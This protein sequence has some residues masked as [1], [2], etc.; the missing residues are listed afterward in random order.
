VT[1]D[2]VER[3]GA[4]AAVI[5]A[6]I[7]FRCV[8]D[9]PGRIDAEGER[10]WRV[11]RRQMGHEV[12]L[13]LKVVRRALQELGEV[14][15][16]KHFP[17]LEDQSLAYRVAE[18]ETPLTCQK[19]DRAR[20]DQPEAPQG[21]DLAPQ[22]SVPSPTGPGTEPHRASAPYVENLETERRKE[23]EAPCARRDL[24]ATATAAA[25][26]AQQSSEQR[27][28]GRPAG[29]R[30]RLAAEIA[31]PPP[32]YCRR[33]MP[34]GTSDPCGPCGDARRRFARWERRYG[35]AWDLL[36]PPLLTKAAAKAAGFMLMAEDLIASRP[37]DGP[38]QPTQAPPTEYIDAQIID[39]AEVGRRPPAEPCDRCASPAVEGGLC[40]RHL[41]VSRFAT[42]ADE[43]EPQP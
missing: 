42:P 43:E 40:G 28:Y 10:W 4:P 22:G 1:P 25:A 36:H 7:R 16:A 24:V 39:T 26:L 6:H 13:T 23:G 32:E 35:P 19:P 34:A 11:S 3:Y 14:V 29:V 8:S 2:E 20:S 15:I 37:D 33:H 21:Q 38:S 30:E 9:G 18:E 5:L 31:P 41:A 12:G 17:P 27:T